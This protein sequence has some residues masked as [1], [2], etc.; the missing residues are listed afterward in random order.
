MPKTSQ[1]L[2]SPLEGTVV[3][4]TYNYTEEQRAQSKALRE[5][6]RI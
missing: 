6:R 4:P 1:V 3:A 2:T 5:V